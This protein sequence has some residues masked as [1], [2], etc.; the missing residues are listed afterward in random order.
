MLRRHNRSCILGYYPLNDDHAC[1]LSPRTGFKAYGR[2]PWDGL[3][4]SVRSHAP[5]TSPRCNCI[6]LVNAISWIFLYFNPCCLSHHKSIINLTSFSVVT[7]TWSSRDCNKP[8]TD[9]ECL[10][11]VNGPW[12][13]ELCGFK[14]LCFSEIF[15]RQLRGLSSSLLPL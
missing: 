3:L 14:L 10:I 8:E 4:S 1:V 7:W 9:V 6:C 5:T 15:H 2:S 11:Q 13:P 12:G